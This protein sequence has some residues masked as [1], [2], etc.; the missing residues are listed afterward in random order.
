MSL[1]KVDSNRILANLAYGPNL[2]VKGSAFRMVPSQHAKEFF[3]DQHRT[4]FQLIP[5]AQQKSGTVVLLSPRVIPHALSSQGGDEGSVFFLRNLLEYT[6]GG[7]HLGPYGVQLISHELIHNPK[8]PPWMV[9]ILPSGASLYL[10]GH[11]QNGLTTGSS[12]HSLIDFD[13]ALAMKTKILGKEKETTPPLADITYLAGTIFS[14]EDL[15]AKGPAFA[16][17][18]LLHEMSHLAHMEILKRWLEKNK[19]LPK[20]EQDNLFKAFARVSPESGEVKLDFAF[21]TFYLEICGFNTIGN[22]FQLLLKSSPRGLTRFLYAPI[23]DSLKQIFYYSTDEQFE[24]VRKIL[25]LETLPTEPS[26]KKESAEL[27]E[28]IGKLAFQVASAINA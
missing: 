3:I 8:R 17:S 21:V 14:G 6:T 28:K 5:V 24:E 18:V 20:S 7:A 19:R 23:M 4:L 9:G 16:A 15:E 13:S 2:D 26:T 10:N 1:I 12:L 27:V 11:Q 25:N 22:Y